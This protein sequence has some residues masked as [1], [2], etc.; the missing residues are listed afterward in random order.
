[1]DTQNHLELIARFLHYTN[2]PFDKWDWDGKELIIF[3]DNKIIERYSFND[4]L[5]IIK[6]FK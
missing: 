4:L 6:N 3:F 1:M 2:E 5:T